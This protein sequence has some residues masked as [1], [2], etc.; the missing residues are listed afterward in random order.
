MIVKLPGV[1][2]SASN[3]SMPEGIGNSTIIR[4]KRFAANGLQQFQPC[5]ERCWRGT[6]FVF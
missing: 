2:F 4:G 3:Y 5:M 6:I 1:K